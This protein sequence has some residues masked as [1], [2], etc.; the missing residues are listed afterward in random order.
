MKQFVFLGILLFMGCALSFAGNPACLKQA[1]VS[2]GK[3]AQ[4][5]AD[6]GFGDQQHKKKKKKKK[7]KGG[8][9]AFQH[10]AGVTFFMAP[11]TA[12]EA[13]NGARNV[14]GT[15]FPSIQLKNMDNKSLRLIVRTP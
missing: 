8:Y 7:K 13:E 14:G 12:A 6:D 15:Y 9:E 1:P 10:G 2:A 3:T 5:F 11:A 4:A